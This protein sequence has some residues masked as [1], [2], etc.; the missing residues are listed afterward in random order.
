[1]PQDIDENL[2]KALSLKTTDG[3]LISDVTENGPAD[4]AGITRGDVIVQFDGKKVKNSTELRNMVAQTHP[5]A[6][7]QII[8]LRDGHEKMLTVV[9]GKRPK[10]RESTLVGENESADRAGKKL[11]IS[12][13]NLTPSLAQQLGYVNEQGV[14]VAVVEP[15]S[16]AAEAGV[17]PGDLIKSV[18]RTEVKN[19]EDFNR[20]MKNLRRGDSV[21][22]LVRRGEATFFVAIQ[23]P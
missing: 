2:A 1:M 17:Q 22:L 18:N 5:G 14:V 16:P 12:I 15:R 3:A 21:A 11:G 13:Q 10:N 6:E 20:E 8:I 23:I 9:L 19:V 4:K 7:V